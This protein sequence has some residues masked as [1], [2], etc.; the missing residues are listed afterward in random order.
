MKEEK[1][2]ELKGMLDEISEQMELMTEEYDETM[3]VNTKIVKP[4]RGGFLFK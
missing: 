2:S 4:V 3:S 1:I